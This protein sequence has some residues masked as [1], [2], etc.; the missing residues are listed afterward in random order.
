MRK[1]KLQLWVFGS[2]TFPNHTPSG[3][4]QPYCLSPLPLYSSDSLSSGFLV[5][6]F[7]GVAGRDGNQCLLGL[8]RSVETLVCAKL[9]PQQW[10][11]V[12]P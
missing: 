7:V 1:S 8:G 4:W 10:W 6:T 2:L 9:N 12:R 11:E 3:H 5:A